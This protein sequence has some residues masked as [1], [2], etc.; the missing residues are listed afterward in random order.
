MSDR[1]DFAIRAGIEETWEGEILPTIIPGYR[2]PRHGTQQVNTVKKETSP[3][4]FLR[5]MTGSLKAAL[6]E[7]LPKVGVEASPESQSSSR[8]AEPKAGALPVGEELREVARAAA[9]EAP[10]AQPR[11]MWLEAPATEAERVAE[12]ARQAAVAQRRR[13]LPEAARLVRD[14][15]NFP[16]L[17]LPWGQAL[18]HEGVCPPPHP[19][20]RT[21]DEG[22]T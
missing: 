4:Q 8:R 22:C 15:V 6:Q 3:S 13:D 10:L 2:R 14:R 16:P 19:A 5:L 18:A 21:I 9:R 11:L 20:A 12:E 17:D 1:K 7:A